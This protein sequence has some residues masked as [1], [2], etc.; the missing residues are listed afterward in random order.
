MN[1]L[2]LILSYCMKDDLST[3]D[4]YDIWFTALGSQVKNLYNEHRKI[5]LLPAVLLTLIDRLNTSRFFYHKREYPIVRAMAAQILLKLYGHFKEKKYLCSAEK[6]LDWL[7]EHC[8]RGDHGYGWG[9]GIC[10]PVA[11]GMIYPADMALATVT[12]Y[13]YEAFELHRKLTAGERYILPIEK[14]ALFFERDLKVLYEDAQMMATSYSTAAD[15]IVVNAVSYTMY[16][17]ILT[18]IRK[19]GHGKRDAQEIQKLYQFIKQKQRMDGSWFYAPDD[20]HSFIDCFH[21]CIVLKNLIKGGELFDLPGC[22]VVVQSGWN[23]LKEHMFDSTVRLFRRFSVANK[24]GVISY[25][26]YD[27]AEAW[28]IA[29]LL[30]DENI[31]QILRES[32]P[33]RFY[34]GKKIYSQIDCCGFRCG[35]C[36]LRWA[37]MPYLLSLC[38]FMLRPASPFLLNKI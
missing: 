32:I 5:G 36:L 23:Y 14:T 24:P 8:T 31:V 1:D 38:N 18:F 27:N 10:W 26:L 22:S 21:T 17:R 33:S 30:Q 28:N 34:S 16:A 15:R 2:D 13:V 19:G 20:S 4:P 29:L 7:L 9:L 11:T 25:D 6:H 37:I 3:H 12:P 35:S